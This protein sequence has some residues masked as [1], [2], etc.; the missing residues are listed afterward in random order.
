MNELSIYITD[1]VIKLK[2][3]ESYHISNAHITTTNAHPTN[4]C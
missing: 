3:S 1:L 4:V 2:E